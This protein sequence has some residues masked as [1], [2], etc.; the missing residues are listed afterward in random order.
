MTPFHGEKGTTW[1]GGFRVPLVMRW[2][3]VIKPNT[4]SNEIVSHEDMLPTF[5]AAAGE[6]DIVEKVKNGYEANGKNWKVHLD[7]YNLLPLFKGEVEKSPRKSIIYF[8]QG[9]ELNAVRYQDW[10]VHFAMQTGNIATSTREVTAWPA[11]VNLRADPY[12]KA[13]HEA[14]MGYLRWYVDNMWIFVPI[15]SVIGDFISTLDG[16]P[17]QKG[18]SLNAAGINYNSLETLKILGEL[19]ENGIISRPNN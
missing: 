18:S 19:K 8:S 12:E 10:K 16:Y 1:E 14:D 4:I 15:Q 17:L 5:L 7:G 2:P 3:G 13:M 11:I 6:P 9:G